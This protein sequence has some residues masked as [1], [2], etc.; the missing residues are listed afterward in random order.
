M[1]LR[2]SYHPKY[3]GFTKLNVK[4]KDI[5]NLFKN[6]KFTIFEKLTLWYNPKGCTYL[7]VQEYHILTY[8]LMT[9]LLPFFMLINLIGIKEILKSYLDNFNRLDKGK[10]CSDTVYPKLKRESGWNSYLWKGCYNLHEKIS[11]K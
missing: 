2:K 10:Y 6:R 1:K 4:S 9:L 11:R 8:I 3:K 5:K 7:I